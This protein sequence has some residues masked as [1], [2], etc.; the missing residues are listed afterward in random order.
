MKKNKLEKLYLGM[1]IGGF[2]L[3]SVSFLLMPIEGMRILPGLCFW[4]GLLVGVAFQITLES[5]RRSFFIRYKVKR[6]K[7][8]TPKCGLLT[9]AS[10]RG[11]AIVDNIFVVSI[12]ATILVFIATKGVGYLCYV[13]ISIML[14]SFCLHCILNGRNYFHTNNQNRVRQVLELKKATTL[15]KGEGDNVKK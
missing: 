10:S 14:L 6:E 13:C 8:Q 11:A 12:P 1:S 7:M 2:T 3:M 15:N 4:I 9:F 5:R